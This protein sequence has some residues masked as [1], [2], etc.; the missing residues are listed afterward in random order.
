LA[1]AI[2]QFASGDAALRYI[3]ANCDI[4]TNLPDIILLDINMP[5]TDG[6]MF[7][8]SYRKIKTTLSKDIVI[9]VVTSSID[10]RDIEHSKQYHEVK[11]FISKP[12]EMERIK[13][14]LSHN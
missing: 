2:H 1:D 6:W 5:V 8:D 3:T 12:L 13:K 14:M 7:L 10:Q 9:Y 11:G 4:P